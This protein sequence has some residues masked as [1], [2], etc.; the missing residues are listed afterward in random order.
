MVDC[1]APHHRGSELLHRISPNEDKLGGTPTAEG[2]RNR[3]FRNVNGLG[4]LGVSATC[5]HGQGKPIEIMTKILL[6]FI[7]YPFVTVGSRFAGFLVFDG[8]REIEKLQV[9]LINFRTFA[10]RKTGFEFFF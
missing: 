1:K 4:W 2:V 10:A 5:R 3:E 8:M 7:S 6:T 9:Q